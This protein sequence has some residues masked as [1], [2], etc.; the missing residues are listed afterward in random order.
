M[1]ILLPSCSL[2]LKNRLEKTIHQFS[3]LRVLK[4][5]ELKLQTSI[6]NNSLV[7]PIGLCHY[8]FCL[9]TRRCLEETTSVSE[10]DIIFNERFDKIWKE[11]KSTR[12]E[13]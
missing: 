4:N 8:I 1:Y 10:K 3:Y 5:I 9:R 6:I 7:F 13:K 11:Q 12:K 2:L